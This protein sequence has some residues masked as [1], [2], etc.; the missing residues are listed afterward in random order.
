MAI[1]KFIFTKDF[2]EFKHNMIFRQ[3]VQAIGKSYSEPVKRGPASFKTI[4]E[5]CGPFDCRLSRRVEFS[6]TL[7]DTKEAWDKMNQLQGDSL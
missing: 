2:G 3:K 5:D 7:K 4:G 1:V 6:F